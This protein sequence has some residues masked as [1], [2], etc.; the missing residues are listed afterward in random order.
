VLGEFE[1]RLELGKERRFQFFQLGYRALDA[2]PLF[3]KSSLLLTAVA[4]DF[5]LI[6]AVFW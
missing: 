6:K 1:L 5:S 4:I 2:M 3:S